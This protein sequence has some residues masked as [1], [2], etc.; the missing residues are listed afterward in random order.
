M[1]G[2]TLAEGLGVV[3]VV[4]CLTGTAAPVVAQALDDLRPTQIEDADVTVT[5]QPVTSG[6]TIAPEEAEALKTQ[7]KSIKDPYAPLGLRRGGM[8]F[9]P[10][11]QLGTVYTS[12]V[13]QAS[14]GSKS[15]IGLR[16]KPALR[17]QSDWSRH[18]WTGSASGDVTAYLK[19]NYVT[20]KGIEAASKFKLDIRHTTWAELEAS[21]GLSQTGSE[22]SE[23]PNTAIGKR[24]DHT[25]TAST[26]LNHDFGGLEGRIKLA[27]ERQIYE[28]VKLAGGGSEDNDDRNNYTPSTSLRLSYA[29]PPALKPFVEVSYA[30]RFHDRKYDRNGLKRNSQG[31]I[32]SAGVV[33]DRGPIW[34]GEAAIVYSVR[35]YADAA[36]DTNSAIGINGNLSWKPTDLTT[37]LLTLGT[38]LDETSSATSSGSK[39]Y[40]SRIDLSRELRENVTMLAGAGLELTRESGQTDKTYT[41]N[42]GID[43]QLNQA[44]SWTAS[45]DGTWFEPATS[46]DDYNEQRLM[47]GIVLRR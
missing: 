23:L 46:G 8:I 30:P 34:T 31:V 24:T 16:I 29:E 39:T 27:L 44:L 14:S 40:T 28:D 21:Y 36:L 43:W 32:A 22:D 7:S 9:Y 10:S 1:K 26:A 42:L 33:L 38:S 15:D 25:L 5:D 18:S 11:L 41:S 12:N 35:D 17:F 6:L 47:T 2:V 20:S 13:S 37:V 4:L 3:G 45:Y 19:E